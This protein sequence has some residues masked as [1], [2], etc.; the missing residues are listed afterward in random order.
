MTSNPMAQEA[1][2]KRTILEGEPMSISGAVNKTFFL[3]VLVVVSSLFTWD[4]A[5][6]GYSDKVNLLTMIGIGGAFIMAIV[7]AFKPQL[8]QMLSIGYALF[9]GLA[10]GTISA[11]FESAYGGIVGQAIMATF[12]TMFVMLGLYKTN[13][14]RATPTFRKVVITATLSVAL[15]YLLV[16]VA[17]FFKI[18]FLAPL[19]QSTSLI[20]VSAIIIVIAALNLILDFDFIEKAA[21]NMMPKYFEW[22]G[23]LMLLVTLVWLYLEF[24]RLLANSRR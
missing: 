16:I 17:S 12:V 23:G 14:L 3:L 20:W 2:L 8:S 22:Y 5:V 21:A 6:K 18:G 19:V 1:V 4:L 9:E 7:A 24:L 11:M 13:I 10:L 15:Y